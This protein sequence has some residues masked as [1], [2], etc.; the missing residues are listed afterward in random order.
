MAQ[1]KNDS[2]VLPEDFS[3]PS[4]DNALIE[5]KQDRLGYAPFAK[6][7]AD[8]ICQMNF[9]EGFVIAVYGS[10][11]FG[12]STLLNF[13]TYYLQQKP[14]SEQPIIVPFNP[15]L[16]S[17]GEDI[18]RRFINELQTV[19]SK[20]KAVPKGFISRITDLAKVVSEI[21][22]PYAQ[23][24]NA[25]VRLFDDKEKETS[26]LKEEVEDTLEQQHPRIV[27]TIDDIDRLSAEEISQLF[28][29]IKSIPNFT[30]VVYLLVFDQEVVIKTLG[31]TQPIPGETYLSQ[32]VQAPFELPLPDKTS[33]RRLLSEKLNG[34][35]A[36]TPKELFNQNRW[37]NVYLQG[38]D[39]F[40]TN[41]RDIVRLTNLLTVTYPGVK[42]EVNSV[43]FIAIEC[44]RAFRPMIYDIIR[45]NPTFFGGTAKTK[46]YLIPTLDEIKDFHHSWL[47]QF[48][49]ED[50]EPIKLLLLHLFPKLEAV[51]RN[52][53]S[54]AQDESIWRKQLRICS[55]DI[56][57]N[58][59]RLVLTQD[60]F[61]DAEI[62]AIF[63]LAKDA[64]AFGEILVELAHQKRSDGTTQ[65]RAFLEQLED[66]TEKEIPTH[67]IP[68]IV[69]A[70]LD[71]GDQ[72]LPP[73]DEPQGMFDFG[74]DIRIERLI[75][76]LLRRIDEQARFET[77]KEAMSNGNALSIIVRE[78]ATL[79]QE[80]GKYEADESIPEEEWLQSVEHL[81]ELEEIALK[82]LRD[83]AQQNSLLEAP[84]LSER[85]HYWQSWAGEEEV[86]QWVE[87][88]IDNDEGL[89]NF[90]EKFL[91][92]DFSEYGSDGTQ[93][94]G[95]R[96]DPKWV[97]PYLEPSLI[98]ER[99]SHLDETSE[100]TE[101]R[102]NAIAQFIRECEMRQ[103]GQDPD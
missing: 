17:G 29:L 63:A 96:L 16:F 70:L 86:K 14:K 66:Y 44:L 87:K 69:K 6:H 51:W 35:L 62:K 101:D 80:Q 7:L 61:S 93:K 65:V 3:D 56:F 94:T 24:S 31:N 15:W 37:G 21:P 71:V 45:K 102:K 98:L 83:A 55:L 60:E 49:N 78:V 54:P 74:N 19:L 23:A 57:P 12:K 2:K 41:P 99:I 50:K 20:F 58:Y 72:L 75:S 103:Q 30:N 8:S 42:G 40:I 5:P 97:E 18:T 22:L 91:Q 47:A 95:Y 26:D 88:I 52:T 33:L 59:F 4:A 100:L 11:G 1:T 36:D 81:K 79:G 9:P 46:G 89:V 10:S 32:I 28:Y 25:L 39:H 73:E 76:Q 67:C 85:L 84:K 43:D 77:L 38:I 92:K 82:R 90:L 64:N 13:L 27:V 34:I 53:S 68:S 48:E